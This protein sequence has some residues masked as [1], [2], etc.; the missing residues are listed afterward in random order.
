[1]QK[2]VTCLGF[3]H[4]AEEAVNFYTSIFPNSR[5]TSLSRNGDSGPGPKGSLL[6]ATFVL[7]GQEFMAL[8][9]G[10]SFTFTVGMSVMV[11]CEDQPEV[12]HLW[13]A[14]V[15]GGQPSRCG[16][17]TDRFGVSWQIVP[18]A[19][20]EMVGDKDPKKVQAVVKAMLTMTKFDIARL[21][22]AYQQ[23]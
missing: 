13:D 2:I 8:N 22:E 21:R 20:I 1:M 16:W 6:A 4:Q 3:D 15:D 10:P 17:L 11:R 23:A 12:D 18:R 14:L 7:D 5:I 9:G 19:F